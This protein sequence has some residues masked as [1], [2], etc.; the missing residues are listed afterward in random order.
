VSTAVLI[1]G[2]LRTF[3]QCLPGLNYHVF[4]KLKDP[5]FF[6]SCAD[7]GQAK[8]AEL[9]RAIGHPTFIE[10]VKQP[11]FPDADKYLPAAQH[12]PYHI[13]VPPL[14]ILRQAWHM[15]RV[16]EFAQDNGA[17]EC[18]TFVRCRPDLWMQG[19]EDDR[20]TH[21][22]GLPVADYAWLPWWGRFGG[23]N[24]RFAIMGAK[25]ALPYFTLYPQINTLL[26][27]G[28]PFHPESLLLASLEKGNVKVNH[29]LNAIFSTLRL[30]EPDPNKPGQYIQQMRPPEILPQEIADYARS[31]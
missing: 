20:F 11:D 19:F 8:D 7:D 10:V 6:V 14:F 22:T 24:D 12:A 30:P 1:S 23:A 2:Q 17:V 4:R 31:K 18:D 3:R 9:I 25:A 29:T 26:E 5:V 28:C 21:Q 16:H 13:S 15:N 27:M